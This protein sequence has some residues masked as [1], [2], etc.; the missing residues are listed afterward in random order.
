MPYEASIDVV[1][2]LRSTL[3][4]LERADYPQKGSS[5]IAAIV[6]HLR[7]TIAELE[8]DAKRP[9]EGEVRDDDG[10]RVGQEKLIG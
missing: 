1:Q 8:G 6:G 2:I 3:Y 10:L 7:L 9:P 5:A 4:L